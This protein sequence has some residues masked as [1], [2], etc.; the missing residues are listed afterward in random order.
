[1]A[2]LPILSQKS[3]SLWGLKS[4]LLFSVPRQGGKLTSAMPRVEPTAQHED[5]FAD[6]IADPEAFEANSRS[7]NETV[8]DQPAHGG[9]PSTKAKFT[10]VFPHSTVLVNKKSNSATEKQPDAAPASSGDDSDF[11]AAPTD[12]ESESEWELDK[13]RRTNGQPKKKSSDPTE[14]PKN[15]KTVL[16]KR[17]CARQAGHQGK[18]RKASTSHSSAPSPKRLRTLREVQEGRK[19][20]K[21]P[22][23]QKSSE[24]V[25]DDDTITQLQ[26][27]DDE[28]EVQVL[29][30]EPP[31]RQIKSQASQR[32]MKRAVSTCKYSEETRELNYPNLTT[33]QSPLQ[34]TRQ[35]NYSANTPSQTLPPFPAQFSSVPPSYGFAPPQFLPAPIQQQQQCRYAVQPMHSQ[36][37]HYVAPQPCQC[38]LSLFFSHALAQP[39]HTNM[40]SAYAPE[41]RPTT[42]LRRL[43][44]LQFRCFLALGP[45]DESA[46]LAR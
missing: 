31:G 25:S 3:A 32:N 6:V 17:S 30:G 26:D 44:R 37:V 18:K 22:K 35:A 29:S 41:L 45:P 34:G 36:S 8:A 24:V 38:A 39:P 12:D 10:S 11:S 43:S 2:F 42:S 7:Y 40:N 4:S 9:G 28:P 15:G 19:G 46:P 16:R 14:V 21:R 5:E 33:G 1:M 27:E 13:M 20:A 23:K